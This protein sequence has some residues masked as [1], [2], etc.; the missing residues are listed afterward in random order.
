MA[1]RTKKPVSIAPKAKAEKSVKAK[2]KAKTQAKTTTASSVKMQPQAK[3][4]TKAARKAIAQPS[5][6]ARAK[7]KSAVAAKPVVKSASQRKATSVTKP[8]AA[9][10]TLASLRTH[11]DTVEKR[12]N[13]ANSLTKSSVKAMQFAF[14]KLNERSGQ[15]SAAQEK[16]IVEYV[17]ALNVH[18]T[19]LIDKT[20]E[21]VAH[22]L[23]VVLDDPR[24]E[25][26]SAALTK[27]NHRITRAESDQATAL[28][29]INEQIANLATVVDRR[30]R[31]ESEQRERA[32]HILSSKIEAVEKSSAEAVSGIGVKIVA[33]T[34]ELNSRTDH[35]IATF[36]HELSDNAT[37][38]QKNFEA[39]KSEID[40]RIE[41]L[42][43]DQR[44]SIPS[45][46]RRM[47]TIVTR[48]ESLEAD[49]FNAVTAQ[50]M[51]A[52]A[53]EPARP[54]DPQSITMAPASATDAF[55]PQPA[56]AHQAVMPPTQTIQLQSP[57]PANMSAPSAAVAVALAPEP[58]P[59]VSKEPVASHIPQEYVPQEYAPQDHVQPAEPTQEYPAQEYR[60]QAYPVSQTGL[61]PA[62]YAASPYDPAVPE[63][64]TGA[65]LQP[66]MLPPPPYST[67]I[68]YMPPPEMTMDEARPG[69][70][71]VPKRSGGFLSKLKGGS[72][73]SAA[74]GSPVK[75]FA[76]M[77]GIVVIGLFAAQKIMPGPNASNPQA[78]V[79]VVAS[80]ATSP[81]GF[82][83]NP[84]FVTAEPTPPEIE[85]MDVVGDYSNEMQAPELEPQANGAP[86]SAQLT[87]E[88]AAANGDMVA[89]FQL[90]LS[91]LE[92]NRNAEAVRLIRLSAN[93]GQP[94]AQYR[95]AKLYENGTG[96]EKD[97]PTAMKLLERSA[98]GGNRIAMH[99]LGHYFAT[100]A[101]N[102]Q[103]DINNAVTWFQRAAERGVLDSQFNLGVLYQEGSG[104]TKSA[105][106]AYVWYAIAGAQGDPMAVQ[107]AEVLARDMSKPQI[108][109]GTARVKAFVPARINNAA[110]GVFGKLPWTKSSKTRTASMNTD[111]RQAQ[112]LLSGLGYEVG[113]PDGA[114]GP[115]TRNAIIRFE[116]SN[117]LP[118]TG[119]VSG[120][121]MDRLSLAAGV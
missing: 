99:D 30:L 3:P 26:I 106:D 114:M 80:T 60:A 83:G 6:K 55:A 85:S 111:V 34:E 11:I 12:L 77:T 39:H 38:Q 23:Q 44:N 89:Q 67:D 25:T 40:R 97:L 19:G 57:Q 79:Q 4:V 37:D 8:A 87:L 61:A 42:E 62:A 36:K 18:L 29:S 100:G 102:D 13:R 95:L 35:R 54:F 22:D 9:R 90:G 110:N 73:R 115:K 63:M 92:A 116:R 59:V 32:E 88:S 46:E 27:A 33:L 10:E 113:A 5:P 16:E 1:S 24:L 121:L 7:T 47:V 72:A 17:E 108:E 20:R 66:D 103:P 96:V 101:A 120:E 49:R 98:K 75:L 82:N 58:A 93:Q 45:I 53:F 86:S 84:A 105:I 112:Q 43:D 15:A 70:D 94:A 52:P 91:H 68:P 2:A 117:G 81:P 56:M 21:D 28:T 107:R 14:N 71:I 119:R 78:D 118:E 41:T 64:A 104:V 69:G 51:A 31:R 48:L 76:L 50:P 74:S 109:Q 65:T